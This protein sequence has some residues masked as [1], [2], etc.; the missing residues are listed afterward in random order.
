MS[1]LLNSA[2]VDTGKFIVGLVPLNSGDVSMM[3]VE[4]L[5]NSL[6]DNSYLKYTSTLDHDSVYD[7]DSNNPTFK[8]F[9]IAGAGRRT[10][11]LENLKAVG[12]DWYSHSGRSIKSYQAFAVNGKPICGGPLFD[13]DRY[14]DE[15]YD[16][17]WYS[18]E[19]S[20]HIT[21]YH[22]CWRSYVVG[23]MHV[24]VVHS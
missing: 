2:S 15:N 1:N 6:K 21:N 7:T 14:A 24:V 9:C 8:V 3:T 10:L 12:I 17:G 22:Y 20:S 16:I 23:S 13:I 5:F 19:D 4:E 18:F 11:T